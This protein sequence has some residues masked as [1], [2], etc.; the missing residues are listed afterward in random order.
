MLL[1]NILHKPHAGVPPQ[2]Q[3]G[4]HAIWFCMQLRFAAASHHMLAGPHTSTNRLLPALRHE[5]KSVTSSG[6]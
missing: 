6:G 2:Q 3:L 5:L 1:R 4:M